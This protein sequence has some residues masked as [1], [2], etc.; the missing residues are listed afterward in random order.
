MLNR[1]SHPGTPVTPPF[2]NQLYQGYGLKKV[3]SPILGLLPDASER[4][5]TLRTDTIQIQ[6]SSPHPQE[7][8][9][10][11]VCLGQ[12]SVCFLSLET[13][14][15]VLETHRNGIIHSVFFCVLRRL[16][17]ARLRFFRVGVC[18]SSVP[19]YR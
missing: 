8:P 16:R 14:L 12:P 11:S 2:K 19:F 1:L 10:A 7:L 5:R 17:A 15:P 9:R 3:T 6:D 18:Q 13:V 4:V